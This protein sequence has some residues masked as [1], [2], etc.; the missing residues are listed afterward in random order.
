MSLRCEMRKQSHKE[1]HEDVRHCLLGLETKVAECAAEQVTSYEKCVAQQNTARVGLTCHAFV[2][3]IKHITF[4]PLFTVSHQKQMLCWLLLKKGTKTRHQGAS[5]RG[6]NVHLARGDVI[7]LRKTSAAF[8]T[9]QR[10]DIPLTF[11]SD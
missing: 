7:K 11:F 4:S 3:K 9:S 5:L 8:V 6:R 1:C 10:A 2:W